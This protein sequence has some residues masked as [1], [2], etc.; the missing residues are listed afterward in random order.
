MYT[1]SI[2]FIALCCLKC[3]CEGNHTDHDVIPIEKADSHLRDALK[4]SADV[5][6]EKIAMLEEAPTNLCEVLERARHNVEQAKETVRACF[7]DVRKAIDAKEIG[8]LSRLEGLYLSSDGIDALSEKLQSF[9]GTSS[10][11]CSSAR[12]LLS[13]WEN[14]PLTA[15]KASN[16]V[17]ISHTVKKAEKLEKKYFIEKSR[18]ISI[19]TKE[20]EAETKEIIT[21]VGNL[22]FSSK[23]V[24][25]CACPKNFVVSQIGVMYASLSWDR[26]A[27]DTE[28]SVKEC[29]MDDDD[30]EEEDDEEWEGINMHNGPNNWCSMCLLKPETEYSF[31][32]RAKRDGIWSKWSETIMGVTKPLSFEGL[33]ND[34]KETLGSGKM[35]ACICGALIHDFST[36]I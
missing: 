35:W 10:S 30:E 12:E 11:I 1:L 4:R 19:D 17:S 8:I 29:N 28:Y 34:L 9:T 26:A 32:V 25:I 23:E 2:F 7:T 15:E 5:L 33:V 31:R 20:I 24:D 18:S 16:V 27:G 14:T 13:Q 36:N 22:E 6:E 3:R 21:A